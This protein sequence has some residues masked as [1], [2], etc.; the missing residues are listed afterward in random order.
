MDEVYGV[1]VRE[2]VSCVTIAD[3]E[4]EPGPFGIAAPA[5]GR[6]V[7]YAVDTSGLA[8]RVRPRK[9]AFAADDLPTARTL[10]ERLGDCG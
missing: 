10:S 7:Q 9:Q 1:L 3:E 8:F 4:F 2:G 5:D 6:G